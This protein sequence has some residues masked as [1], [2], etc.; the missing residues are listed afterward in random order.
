MLK[1]GVGGS[2]VTRR[3][4]LIGCFFVFQRLL[5]DLPLKVSDPRH[6]VL[7]LGMPIY[8]GF[9]LSPVREH[10][11]EK[12]DVVIRCFGSAWISIPDRR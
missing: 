1:S 3:R 2:S 6:Q 12:G 5:G 4:R 11:F 10:L 8:Q 7:I 9:D